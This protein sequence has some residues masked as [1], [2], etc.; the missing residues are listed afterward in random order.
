MSKK[1]FSDKDI[2][3]LASNNFVKSVSEKGITYSKEFK[4]LFITEYEKRKT[5]ET[6]LWREWIWCRRSWKRKS[7]IF[8][9]KDLSLEGE[10]KPLEAQNNLIKAENKLL[11]KALHDGKGDGEKEIKL[12]TTLKFELIHNIIQEY[13]LKNM[14]KYLC[15][16]VGV[17]RSG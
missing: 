1:V 16:L 5:T 15:T 2:K 10:Y 7:K 8:R 6:G 17:S 14:V 12:A 9:E 13:R 4:R 11:K 3:T